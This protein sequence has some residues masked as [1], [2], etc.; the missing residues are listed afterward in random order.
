M[1]GWALTASAAAVRSA[2][3][4]MTTGSAAV[5]VPVRPGTV[6]AEAG[7]TTPRRGA[8]R[9]GGG[10]EGEGRSEGFFTVASHFLW[11]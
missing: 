5:P 3:D 7:L 2:A 1:P 4:A 8:G 9:P 10:D 11:V 6:A